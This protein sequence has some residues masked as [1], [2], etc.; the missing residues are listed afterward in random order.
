MNRGIVARYVCGNVIA[1]N[2]IVHR[3]Y[4]AMP[5]LKVEWTQCGIEYTVSPGPVQWLQAALRGYAAPMMR[6]TKK[7]PSCIGCVVSWVKA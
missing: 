7:G 4:R 2:G 5:R 6:K 1:L 3:R